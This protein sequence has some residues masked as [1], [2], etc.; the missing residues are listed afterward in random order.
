MEQKKIEPI[1]DARNLGKAKM[2]IL[3]RFVVVAN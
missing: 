3:S 1:R 2:L